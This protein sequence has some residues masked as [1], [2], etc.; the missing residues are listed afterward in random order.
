MLMARLSQANMG[1]MKKEKG[2]ISQGKVIEKI[3]SEISSN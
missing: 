1:L 2:N 3:K